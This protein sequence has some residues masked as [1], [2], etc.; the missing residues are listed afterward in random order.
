MREYLIEK[1]D[2]INKDPESIVNYYK[3]RN[4]MDLLR[5]AYNPELK[6][7]LPEG[8]PYHKETK[9]LLENSDYSL[10]IEVRRFYIFTNGKLKQVKREFNYTQIYEGLPDEEKPI[11]VAVKDQTLGELYPNIDEDLL[12]KH[13]LIP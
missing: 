4:V 5:F 12:R 6:F 10:E 7:D 2:K 13:K 3:D 11:F 8:I 9:Q 1:L